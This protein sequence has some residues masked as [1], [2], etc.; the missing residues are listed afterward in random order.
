MAAGRRRRALGQCESPPEPRRT[1]RREAPAPLTYP[2]T[3]Q[4]RKSFH[5]TCYFC[6]RRTDGRTCGKALLLE[7]GPASVTPITRGPVRTH[8]HTHTRKAFSHRPCHSGGTDEE[9]HALHQSSIFLPNVFNRRNQ[10]LQKT[11]GFIHLE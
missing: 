11:F 5:S 3:P 1:G 4:H 10:S 6:L 7:P 2:T 8:S 9:R